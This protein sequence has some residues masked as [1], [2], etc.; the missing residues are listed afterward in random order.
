[1][2]TFPTAIDNPQ[3]T[4]DLLG[5]Y[6]PVTYGGADLVEAYARGTLAAEQQLFQNILE[7]QYSVSRHTCPV[8]NTQLWYAVTFKQSEEVVSGIQ[9]LYPVPS[10]LKKAHYAADGITNPTAIF[11]QGIDFDL[12]TGANQIILTTSLF[13]D[14]RITSQP[15]VVNN[16][17]VD[18]AVTLWFFR[19]GIDNDWV[20]EQFGYVIP[21]QL[22]SSERY[23]EAVNT[24]LSSYSSATSYDDVTA[25]L[26]AIADSPRVLT[27][28]EIVEVITS[29]AVALLVITDKNVYR[30]GAGATATVGIGQIVN[31]GDQLSDAV[32]I[33][34]ASMGQ[35][36]PIASVTLGAGFLDPSI[37]GPLTFN[38]ANT[39]L[40]VTL[41]VLGYTKV[42]WALGGAPADVT[43]F[44]N[45]LHTKG[46]A[47]GK[48]LAMCMDNRP[49]PQPTQPT[50]FNLPA[51]I[52]PMLFLYQNVF[53]ANAFTI[54]LKT[55]SFGTEAL[56]VD[57]LSL[58]RNIVPPHNAVITIVV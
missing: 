31:R 40:N 30:F 39:P 38:N 35:A 5:S 2:F 13:S 56:G 12:D 48:T 54:V 44:F 27:D 29:D 24:V 32:A 7:L 53:R 17:V 33:Y 45:I 23:R 20:Y 28:G 10:Q 36:P 16:V 46:I 25:L 49:Q 41:N 43:N 9:Y 21:L 51:T 47:A 4:I 15:I 34:E 52:N 3:R 57:L 6:W 37:A 11:T 22:P 50:A 1:M 14:P 42:D 8:F 55:A 18:Q 19:A 26:E 58:L